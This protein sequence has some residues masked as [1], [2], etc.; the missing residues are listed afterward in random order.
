MNE[1][2]PDKPAVKLPPMS[3]G[4]TDAERE[5]R[6]QEAI[7]RVTALT[8]EE[9]RANSPGKFS[10]LELM[11]V[12]TLLAVALGL[13]R[14]L[15]IWGGLIAFVGSALWGNLIYPLWHRHD[16]SRQAAMFDGVWGLLMPTVCLLCDPFVFANA[17]LGFTNF[18]WWQPFD[19][20]F[21]FRRESLAAA[22][23]VCWQMTALL[24][25]LIFR[26]WLKGYAG[27]FLGT[28]TVGM[29]LSAVLALLLLVP[30]TSAVIIGIELLRY[31]PLFPCYVLTRR[32]RECVEMES[33][34]DSTTTLFWLL[35][36]LGFVLAIIV[37][38]QIAALL[39]SLIET[40][41]LRY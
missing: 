22:C 2:K 21:T 15:G 37:P 18:Q 30:P 17:D 34:I 32:M 27:F 11:V 13:V 20:H 26:A 35:T 41:S 4:Q 14:S 33:S 5:A 28:W 36:V 23:L 9:A 38:W 40:P 29:M 24:I 7:A 39:Q 25:W 12:M 31:T 8:R 1:E 3:G 10:L 16:V 19:F 6:Y